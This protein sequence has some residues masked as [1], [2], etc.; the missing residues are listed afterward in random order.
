MA[1]LPPVQGC[2]LSYPRSCVREAVS[3][4]WNAECS[5]ENPLSTE[6]KSPRSTANSQ[7]H[8]PR[9]KSRL[10]ATHVTSAHIAKRFSA[11]ALIDHE[12][13][14]LTAQLQHDRRGKIGPLRTLATTSKCCNA[15]RH[16][17]HSC[18]TQHLCPSNDSR[19]GRRRWS[20]PYRL[21][22]VRDASSA[23]AFSREVRRSF[24]LRPGLRPSSRDWNNRYARWVECRL[25][26]QASPRAPQANRPLAGK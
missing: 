19:A 9:N 15:V 1:R 21:A 8:N 3:S 17:G 24:R 6:A 5:C 16:C 7:L 18:I 23:R 13:E 10:R 2:A 22:V 12:L 11:R 14:D 25:G 20:R 4:V 26:C